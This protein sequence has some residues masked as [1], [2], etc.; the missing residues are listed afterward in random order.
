MEND[1]TGL[2]EPTFLMLLITT[3]RLEVPAERDIYIFGEE[4]VQPVQEADVIAMSVGTLIANGPA[5]ALL[6]KP[7]MSV[8]VIVALLM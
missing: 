6:G 7:S 4:M 3:V 8:M 2:N 1:P 5:G